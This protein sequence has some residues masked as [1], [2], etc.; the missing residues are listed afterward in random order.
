MNYRRRLSIVMVLLVAMG[1]LASP[2]ALWAQQQGG[3]TRY[4]Y[5]DN[6]RLRAVILPTGE[7]AIYEYDAAGNFT[8][9]RRPAA[10]TLE[11]L[12]FFP[13]EGG[14]GDQVTI[15]GAG[16][17]PGFLSVTFNGATATV[18]QASPA[19]IVA[20]VPNAA[21]TGLIQANMPIGTL[22]T[23]TPFTVLPRVRITPPSPIVFAGGTVQFTA[24]VTPFPSDQSVQWSVNGIPGGSATVG[25]ISTTGLYAAPNQTIN[26]TIRAT[27]VAAPT[28]FG[29]T[30][31]R[32]RNASDF[33]ILTSPGVS[34]LKGTPITRITGLPLS[35]LRGSGPYQTIMQS[36]PV[37]VTIG[38][39]ITGI[40]PNNLVRGA[41]TSITISGSNLSSATAI[42]FINANGT[43][44]STITAS[45]I[46][47][48]PNGDSLTASVNVT[49]S[50]T[51]GQRV[52]MV[53]AAAGTSLTK[54][55]N[56][57]T[58]TITSP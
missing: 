47:V 57:N 55:V 50:A 29:E 40:M 33:A 23:P 18:I 54:N 13:H 10:N 11:F 12:S 3:I 30:Q 44:D 43:L 22:A 14:A 8:S 58:I 1:F 39:V 2:I 38:P 26:A 32:V 51:L 25:T 24:T 7:I 42:R 35:V 34:V 5:D 17:G 16:I 19:V 48:N 46:V 45:N 36:I 53:E 4:V 6:G 15:L 9:I 20:E 49:A 21:T 56:S 31:A 28:L 52:I 27:S 37:S 41:T